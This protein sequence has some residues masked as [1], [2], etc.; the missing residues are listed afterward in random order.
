MQRFLLGDGGPTSRECRI[1]EA[2]ITL[3]LATNLDCDEGCCQIACY[4]GKG[5]L[6]LKDAGHAVRFSGKCRR[7]CRYMQHS[8]LANLVWEGSRSVAAQQRRVSMYYS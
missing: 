6:V 8:H 3:V 5:L 2:I 1:S 7:L 4:V